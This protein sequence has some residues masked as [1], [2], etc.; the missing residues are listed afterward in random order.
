MVCPAAA[1]WWDWLEKLGLVGGGWAPGTAHGSSGQGPTTGHARG[2]GCVAGGDLRYRAKYDDKDAKTSQ[3][4]K[5]YM[6]PMRSDRNASAV[7]L[8]RRNLETC[9]P[10]WAHMEGEEAMVK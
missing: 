2:P 3:A 5:N 7:E 9:R 4:V 10:N 8:A 6:E 1:E